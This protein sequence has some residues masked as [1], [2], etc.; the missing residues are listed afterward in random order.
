MSSARSSARF[1]PL[2]CVVA[3]LLL[4]VSTSHALAQTDP[5]FSTNFSGGWSQIYTDGDSLL[6]ESDGWYLDSDFA[7]RVAPALWLGLS[8]NG[9][10][11][12]AEEDLAGG[13]AQVEA[14]LSLFAI[15][16]RLRYVFSDL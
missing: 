8:F 3:G 2:V 15:E 1:G 11:H 12:N 4:A 7:G 13:F 14:D 5:G 16:P 9:S 10:Y 6:D